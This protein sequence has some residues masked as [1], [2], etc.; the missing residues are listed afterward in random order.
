MQLNVTP[1]KILEAV[2]ASSSLQVK[3]EE[4]TSS[5]TSSSSSS[6]HLFAKIRAKYWRPAP[7]ILPKTSTTNN[8]NNNNNNNSSSNGN[9]G[10]AKVLNSIISNRTCPQPQPQKQKKQKNIGSCALCPNSS[11]IF[12]CLEA[13]TSHTN[14]KHPGL[15]P[16][17]C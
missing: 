10:K 13:L 9:G 11:R 12:K 4:E 15:Q 1:E 5:S 16:E 8:N 2:L 6:P 17:F 7:V 3:I 14:V